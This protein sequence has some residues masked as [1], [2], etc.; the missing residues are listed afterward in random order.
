M[1]TADEL[2]KETG[3]ELA[4]RIT[5]KGIEIYQDNYL[6]GLEFDFTEKT[7]KI[8]DYED[9]GIKL[10]VQDLQAIN[11]KCQELRLDLGGVLSERK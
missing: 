2:L 3:W 6:N 9:R 8:Y 11:K 5:K 1:K 10:T 4:N 7:V